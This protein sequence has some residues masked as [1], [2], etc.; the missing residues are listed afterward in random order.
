[1][2]TAAGIGDLLRESAPQVLGVLT[3]RYGVFDACEDAVQEA[4]LAAAV[5]WPEEGVPSSPRAW[6][7]TVASR[8]LVDLT[9]S[10]EARRRREELVAAMDPLEIPGPDD[11]PSDDDDTLTLLF[12]CCHPELSASS[13]IALTLRAV[14]GL[15]TAEIARAFLVPEATM[16]QRI[17]RAKQRIKKSG[18]SF[19]MPPSDKRAARLRVVLHVLYLIFNEGYAAT[20]GDQLHRTDLTGE[21]IRL[22]RLAHALLPGED[23]LTGLLAL[24]LLTDARRPARTDSRGFLV[25]LAEQD[26][27]RWD[28]AEITEGTDLVASS[29]AHGEL[30]EYQLQA[31][32]AAVHAEASGMA[33]TD[34]PQILVLYRILDRIAANPMIT[35]NRAVAL[36]MVEGPRAGLDLLDTVATDSRMAGH[37]R[38]EAARGHLLEM[39]GDIAAAREC[40]RSAARRTPSIPE[41]RY[42]EAQ[43]ARLAPA[44]NV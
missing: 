23:E 3:R 27:T 29:L 7:I 35:L 28:Q 38:L 10:E 20:S 34:W 43:D 33:D 16:A 5:Q 22:T 11:R 24:M 41:R 42:L 18:V 14:G 12:L 21:A 19:R 4:L 39:T 13:Q 32:I 26:R 6:L 30:G 8:R 44:E 9:R 17:S 1:M 15:T 31:A 2:S 36:A 25:P 37:H 40:F